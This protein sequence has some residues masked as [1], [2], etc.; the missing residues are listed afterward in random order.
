M[1]RI[2]DTHTGQTVLATPWP[3]RLIAAPVPAMLYG[4][5]G[6]A[7]IVASALIGVLEKRR[8]CEQAGKL[9]SSSIST[10]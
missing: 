6:G 7:F 9:A 4:L 1:T 3:K 8:R 2:V 10:L 5:A